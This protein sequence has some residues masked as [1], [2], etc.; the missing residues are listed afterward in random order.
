VD[1]EELKA[2][3]EVDTSQ[4][5]HELATFDVTVPTILNYLKQFSKVKKLDR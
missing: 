1:N 5:T 3:V 4:T 2:V